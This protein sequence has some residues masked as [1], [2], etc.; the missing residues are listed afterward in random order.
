MKSMRER[1]ENRLGMQHLPP[2]EG[3]APETA[4]KNQELADR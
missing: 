3:L 1:G 4:L 2:N